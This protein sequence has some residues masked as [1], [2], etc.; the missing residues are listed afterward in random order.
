MSDHQGPPLVTMESI[1]S[2]QLQELFCL[3]SFSSFYPGYHH[4]RDWLYTAEP[5]SPAATNTII[6]KAPECR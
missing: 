2:G 4:L 6:V 5:F 1:R 3:R